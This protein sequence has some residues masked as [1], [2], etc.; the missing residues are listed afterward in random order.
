MRFGQVGQL[1]ELLAGTNRLG[2]AATTAAD[3]S[4][5][6][7]GI[8]EDPEVHP[9]NHRAQVDQLHAVAQIGLVRAIA[10]DR[11]AHR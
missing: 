1:V 11:L 9:G 5:G 2:P 3:A 6:S 7:Q 8:S 4:T 10:V